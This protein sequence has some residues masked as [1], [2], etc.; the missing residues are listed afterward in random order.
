VNRER[1]FFHC[2][3]CGAGGDVFK[4]IEL[5]EQVSFP[6]AVRRVAAKIGVTVPDPAREGPGGAEAAAE[7]EAWLR[8]HEIAAAYYRERLLAP[9]GAAARRYLSDRGVTPETVDQLGMGFAPHVKDELFGR[10]LKQGFERRLV[11]TSGLVATR[12]NGDVVDRFRNRLMIP[13]LRDGGSVVAFGGRALGA[14]QLPKYLNSPETSIYSKGRLLYGLHLSKKSIREKGYAVIVEGYFDFAQLWQAGV[15]GAVAVCGTALTPAQAYLLRRFTSKVILSFDPD[16][17]GRGATARSSE[18]LVT[19]GFQVNVA[20][21]PSGEDPDLFLRSRGGEAYSDL[22]RGSKP[23][24][25]HLLDEAAARQDLGTDEGRRAFLTEMLAVAGRIPDAAARD[26]FADRLAVKARITE[27]VVRAEIRRAAAGRRT[28]VRTQDAQP[29]PL[30]LS[31]KGILWSAIHRPLEAIQAV[32]ALEERDVAG[33]ASG[34]ILKMIKSLRDFPADRL[35]TALLERLNEQERSL[36]SAAA[37]EADQPGGAA[38]CAQ[39]LK[40]SRLSRDLADI[41]L[42][43]AESLADGQ[44]PG[45]A[46]YRQKLEIS[47]RLEAFKT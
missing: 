22:L 34:S 1:A 9:G 8:M 32:E 4:F 41:Q 14:D 40:E 23:Y 28:S 18:V 5:Q 20:M 12:E 29:S 2:F 43:I 31:E 17:A 11:L 3:G 19:E 16:S 42:A 44:S 13:I 37:A 39:K 30:G 45:D 26:Q 7:R 6:D 33:L 46:L 10:L 27:E 21:L 36:I 24:L 38:A 47:R 15:A 35:P 25:E